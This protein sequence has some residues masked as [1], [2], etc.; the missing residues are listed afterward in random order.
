MTRTLFSL[1]VKM[2][3][4]GRK[5]FRDNRKKFVNFGAE[6]CL[7]EL[8][9]ECVKP[10]VLTGERVRDCRT[11]NTVQVGQRQLGQRLEQGEVEEAEDR[12]GNQAVADVEQRLGRE[13]GAAP[14]DE[15]ERNGQKK[16]VFEV[17]GENLACE[18]FTICF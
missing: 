11:Q 9:P 12:V 7:N 14:D 13:G 3:R 5:N 18:M 6:N 10:V 2:I 17:V 16:N 1:H 15:V 4:R 8:M